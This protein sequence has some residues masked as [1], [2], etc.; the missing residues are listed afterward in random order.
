MRACLNRFFSHVALKLPTLVT[1]GTEK[2]HAR[3]AWSRTKNTRSSTTRAYLLAPVRRDGKGLLL[4]VVYSPGS[5]TCIQTSTT[6]STKK[7]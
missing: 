1:F 7:S 5:K 2:I 3:S 4:D 6:R